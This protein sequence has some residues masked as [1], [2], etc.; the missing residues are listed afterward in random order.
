MKSIYF[1]LLL[2]FF[3]HP[4]ARAG[5]HYAAT[6]DL[7]VVKSKLRSIVHVDVS[8]PDPPPTDSE[9]SHLE[10]NSPRFEWHGRVELEVQN[11]GSKNIKSIYWDFF[12]IAEV[13]SEKMILSYRIR[14]K[15][16]IGPGQTVKVTGWIMDARLKDLRK[17][18][19]EGLLQGQAEI[20]RVNYSDR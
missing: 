19:R 4:T 7:I 13:N 3:L 8:D 17:H 18:L 15:K 10:M 9:S 6:P 12:L 5:T 11:I 16:A 14:S 1:A 20:K 2:A